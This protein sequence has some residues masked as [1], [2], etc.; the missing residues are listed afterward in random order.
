[1]M[2]MCAGAI[3]A[4]LLLGAP[5]ARA[6]DAPSSANANAQKAQS[7][8]A[9]SPGAKKITVDFKGTLRDGLK[10]I[11]TLGGLNLVIT[12][13]LDQPAQIFLNGV[14]AEEALA[15]VADA[16][17][18]KVTHQGSIWTLRPM[19][20]QEQAAEAAQANQTVVMPPLPPAAVQAPTPP[21][22]PAAPPAPSNDASSED[23]DEAR[24][25]AEDAAREAQEQAREAAEEAREQ[26][27]EAREEARAQAEEARA[28]AEQMREQVRSGVF[29]K[30]FHEGAG[31]NNLAGTGSLTVEEGQ[32]FDDVVSYGGSLRVLGHVKN[33]A[34]AYGGNIYLGPNSE[35]NGNVVTFGGKIDRD[36]GA[37]VHGDVV[38][39]GSAGIGRDMAEMARRAKHVQNDDDEATEHHHGSRLPSFLLWFAVLFGVGFLATMIFPERMRVIESELRRDPLRCGITGLLGTIGLLPA[40]IA[41]VLTCIGIVFIPVLLLAAMLASMVGFSAMAKEIGARL[42]LPPMRKTQAMVLALGSLILLA[43]GFVPVLGPITL[44]LVSFLSFGVILRTRFG[45]RGRMGIPEPV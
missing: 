14:S 7:P 28:Q 40:S 34:V 36:P 35:V 26:A 37:K 29:Q 21:A 41:L 18:L 11:A 20:A 13:D 6:A 9:A 25:D 17:H 43:V 3:A 19:N 23:E 10:K 16:H 32:S 2:R 4:T 1:M 15:T 8:V 31:K 30:L 39:M 33:D 12:G 38:A 24:E 44:I 5:A 22:A 42:P 45:T 27:R